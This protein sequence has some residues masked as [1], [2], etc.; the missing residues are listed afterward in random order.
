MQR[1]SKFPDF[2]QEQGSPDRHRD[3]A[4]RVSNRPG[5]GAGDVAEQLA[6]QQLAGQTGTMDS[7]ERPVGTRAAGM[8][9]ARQHSLAG[10][11]FATQEDRS[12]AIGRLQGKIEGLPH[13][14][15]RGVQV[16]FRH[17]GPDLLLQLLDMRLE[18]AH[19]RDSIQYQSQLFRR[20]GFGE[21]IV[22]PAPHRLDGG[23]DGGVGGD[24]DD[25]KAGGQPQELGQHLQ[26]L[27]APQSE[28]QERHIEAAIPQQVQRLR[29]VAGLGDLMVHGF[30]G[31]VQRTPQARFIVNNQNVH[32]IS[33]SST[34]GPVLQVARLF[35]QIAR[36][37][38]L[39]TSGLLANSL[40]NY[41]VAQPLV[42][43][44]VFANDRR[45]HS[46]ARLS[47][48]YDI[49]HGSRQSFS[50]VDGEGNA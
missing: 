36:R 28:I 46:L 35:V 24:H 38:L 17:D 6:L 25:L 19:P 13:R 44:I 30:Q 32:G 26:P 9:R 4:H 40:M 41:T 31:D 7:D 39:L 42:C 5:K 37:R 27:L 48:N 10:A 49:Q 22:S 33:K 2:V 3:L 47:K 23:S 29:A 45:W 15:V 12:L 21:V 8:D 43:G 14:R 18:T 50:I 34:G 16:G 11:A 20:V 1:A